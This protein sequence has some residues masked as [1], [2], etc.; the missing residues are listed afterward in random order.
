MDAG[1]VSTRLS[2][3]TCCMAVGAEFSQGAQKKK[4]DLDE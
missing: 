2:P 4:D 1:E 3:I